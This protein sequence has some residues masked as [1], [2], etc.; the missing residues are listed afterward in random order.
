MSRLIGR[1]PSA[2]PEVLAGLVT[3]CRCCG[4]LDASVAA[5]ERALALDPK[6]RTSVPHTWF[7]QR[8]YKRLATVGIP[9]FG[10]I[11]PIA[12]NELGRGAAAIPVMRDLES[13]VP[14]RLRD[15]LLAARM[16]LEGNK[17]ESI[18]AIGRLTSSEFGDPEGLFYLARHLAHL[19]EQDA[20]LA[21]LDRIIGGGFF[22]LPVLERDPWLD[23]LRQTPAFTALL[24]RAEGL[25]RAAAEAFENLHGSQF[26]G[27]AAAAS[28]R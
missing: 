26:L 14:L 21:L 15:F 19:G 17:K 12:M 1:G 3:A 7:L 20:A 11:V 4:L 25:H 24:R 27:L 18:A 23:P 10:Y 28:A 8:N 6:I 9:G 2:D 22:C 13:K 16:F 5:H